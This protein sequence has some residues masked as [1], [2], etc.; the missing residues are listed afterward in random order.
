MR[1]GTFIVLFVLLLFVLMAVGCSP[2]VPEESPPPTIEEEGG[3]E[4]AKNTEEEAAQESQ[5]TKKVPPV[6]VVIDNAAVARP[7]SGLQKATVVY[8][9]LAEGGVTRLLA[10]FDTLPEENYV[11]GPV[12]SMRPYFAQQAMEHGGVLAHSGFSERTRQMIAGLALRQITS[13]RHFF[14]DSSRKAPHNLYTD[15][16]KL[17]K[18]AGHDG[19]STEVAAKT[20]KLPSQ[21][22]DGS[23]LEVSYSGRNKVSYT[24]EESLQVYHRFINGNPH[25]D[26]ETGLQYHAR[27]VIVRHTPHTNVPGT[28][29]VD[30][31]L[32]G[33]GQGL[34]L[35]AGLQFE[36]RWQH[37]NGVTQ[38]YYADNTPVNLTYGNTW[39]QVVR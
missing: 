32:K 37:R 24:Y 19:Q 4:E 30:I 29:L 9:F 21:S 26:R 39:V 20:P 10:V 33:E 25:T 2:N 1:K 18:A 11:I 27:R 36:I 23:T 7:Q 17:F 16:E 6:T 38:Y 15:I 13:G 5:M 28:D 8:E 3:A 14:R 34:L 31:E 35:E 12:R 22:Q